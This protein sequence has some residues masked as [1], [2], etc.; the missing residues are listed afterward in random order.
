MESI[1]KAARS[2]TQAKT[3]KG[4]NA[5]AA[6]TGG[7]AA[8]RGRGGYRGSSQGGHRGN[9]HRGGRGGGNPNTSNPG[10]AATRD[11]AELKRKANDFPEIKCFNCD[12][13]GHYSNSCPKKVKV[14]RLQETKKDKGSTEEPPK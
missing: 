5:T 14:N 2:S 12:K 1:D 11:Q 7:A 10:G 3:S 8:S 4:S 13:M 6:I 9:S